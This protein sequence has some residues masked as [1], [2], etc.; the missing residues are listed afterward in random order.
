MRV[1]RNSN[2]E[3]FLGAILRGAA[4]ILG[5]SSTNLILINERRSEVS[6]LVGTMAVSYP[7]LEQIERVVGSS[8]R[9]ITLP[10]G[11]VVDSMVYDS[12]RTRSIRETSSLSELVGSAFAAAATGE[13]A[14]LAGDQRFICVPA[15]TGSRSYGVLLFTK[16]GRHP[17][18][19]QQRELVVRYARRI[20]EIVEND[21][22]GQGRSALER[23]PPRGPEHLLLDGEGALVGLSA[24][25]HGL[26]ATIA[27]DR[28][29]TAELGA[30][31]AEL[32]RSPQAHETTVELAALDGLDLD[33]PLR[34]SRLTL[35]GADVVLCSMPAR[36]STASLEG[37]LLQLTL[38]EA[39]P[40][41][42]LDPELRITSCNEA[43]VQLF[44]HDA[45]E[46]LKGR[47]VGSLFRD[48]A[49]IAEILKQRVLDPTNPYSE[50]PTVIVRRDGSL[51]PARVEALLLA[52]D[53]RGAVGFLVLV[54]R[55]DAVERRW[56]RLV[57]Q[58]RMAT[59]G[60]MATQLAHELRNPLL[61]VGAT[62]E[63]LTDDPRTPEEQ[64]PMLS[65]L[66]REIGR[67]DMIL[68]D[69][70]AGRHDL[71]F[72]EV[73]LAR[74]V[75]DTRRLLQGAQRTAGKQI[76]VDVPPDLTLRADHDALKHV[77]FNLLLNAL[78]V[79][80]DGGTV[81][82]G[83][84]AGEHDVTL[85]VQDEGPGLGSPA[86]ECFQP[87][88]TTKQHGTGLG[89]AVCHKIVRS[90]G[91]MMDLRDREQGGC[92]AWVIL[93]RR[94]ECAGAVADARSEQ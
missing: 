42:F 12:W 61:A 17:F 16:E 40:A 66:A 90:H 51:R 20:G 48:P 71:S 19:R 72:S 58:E 53:M 5:C 93:P 24:D 68:R 75:E 84:R 63:G 80:P 41:M 94:R 91:G 85:F 78:E 38:G 92:E 79:S 11:A 3:E 67:M 83:A 77:T 65:T 35:R 87:F 81:R 15:L 89:L 1:G 36:T 55:R 2:L 37:Q 59:M 39:A 21:L 44:R 10:L 26:A 47:A 88:F 14:R 13:V 62:L 57:A 9:R 73:C 45:E 74:V 52:D 6:I 50:S 8:L 4:K 34:L 46:Q 23:T 69:Y 29:A 43:A 64:R 60:E 32:L 86:A 27:E 22:M 25:P 76:V 82:C 70:L 30:R 56:D 33:G 31:A 18:S 49:E 28:R 7:V 54:R